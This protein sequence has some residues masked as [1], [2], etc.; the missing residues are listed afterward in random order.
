MPPR[1]RITR[2]QRAGFRGTRAP[3][4]ARPPARSAAA[5]RKSVSRPKCRFWSRLAEKSHFER[6]DQVVDAAAAGEHRRN[7]HQCARRGGM[8]LE[9]SMRGSALRRHE[10]GRQPVDQCERELAG[11]QHRDGGAQR[12]AP[13]AGHQPARSATGSHVIAAVTT[14]IAPR[15]ASSGERPIAV[16]TTS[17]AGTTVPRGRSSSRMPAIDQVVARRAR[18]AR[19]RRLHPCGPPRRAPGGARFR[20]PAL[21]LIAAPRDPLDHLP[22]AVAGSE[23]HLGVR[24]CRVLAQDLVHVAHRLDEA[25]PV[26]GR[27]ERRLPMMLPIVTWSAAWSGSLPAPAVRSSAHPRPV[28]ARPRSARGPAPDSGPAGARTNSDTNGC[29]IGGFERA[30]SAITRIRLL[31]SVSTA[32]D[33]LVGPAVGQIAVDAARRD[34]Q[35]HPAQVLDQRKAQHDRDRPELAELQRRDALVRG[36]EAT[37]A[38]AVRRARRRGR[39]S[40]ARCRRPGQPGDEP[41][42]RGAAARGCSRSADAAAPCGSVPRSGT[43]CRAATR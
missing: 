17:A 26:H 30:M 7:D 25:A 6:L 2:I 24:A 23:I 38:I 19:S 33:H 16:R 31:G 34:A 10:Q 43:S 32:V 8:P 27:E 37:E 29:G 39:S 1:R 36:Q 20:R 4:A 22:V 11:R 14:A 41:L 15:Y 35:R 13:P 18:D 42:R 28:A 3:P 40:R 5:S 9:K 21:R 12:K